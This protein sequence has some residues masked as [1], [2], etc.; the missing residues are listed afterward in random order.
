MGDLKKY[1]ILQTD[2]EG[3]RNLAIQGI[4]PEKKFLR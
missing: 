1:M 3:K 4:L 2:F